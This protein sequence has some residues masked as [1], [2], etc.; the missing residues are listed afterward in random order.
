MKSAYELAM[1]RL[2]SA[3]PETS[4]PL[5][6]EQK[7]RLADLEARYKAKIAER[8][9]FLKK[10]LDETLEKGEAEEA[11]KIRKLMSNERARLEEEKEAEKDKV[12]AGRG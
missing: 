10:A 5:S 7:N 9:I 4:T 3:D 12:R 11:E 1:E 8:E 6:A 2:Q